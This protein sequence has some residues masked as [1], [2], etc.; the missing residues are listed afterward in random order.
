[1]DLSTSIH[2]AESHTL[3]LEQLA[4]QDAYGRIDVLEQMSEDHF[5]V[6]LTPNKNTVLHIAAQ[7]G[8]LDCVQYILGLNSSSSLLLKPNLKGDT[9]LHLVAREG[10]LI[11]VK[12]LIDA[13]KR[14]HQEIES[15]VGGEKAI[16]RMTNEEEN[17]MVQSRGVEA[18]MT[19]PSCTGLGRYFEPWKTQPCMSQ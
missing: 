5:V 9:P 17:T 12:A 3:Y 15:G 7:F 16:M 2:T 6:Q 4:A 13:A 18:D 11:V 14:L 8:Q 19:R 10:H 1:M